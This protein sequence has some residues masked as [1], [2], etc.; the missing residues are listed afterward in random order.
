MTRRI[1][2]RANELL[3]SRLEGVARIPYAR[4]RRAATTH[5]FDYLRTYVEDLASVVDMEKI[6]AASLSIGVDP[7]GGASAAYWQPIAERYGLRLEVVNS[8]V[9]PRFGFMPLDWD[10]RIRMDC[11]SPHA[12]A[13]L[14]GLK[15]RFD[16]AFG[17]DPDADRHGIVTRSGGLMNPNH[18]LAAA[19]DY[20]FTHR[21]QWPA[22]AAVG[23][24]VVSSIFI[25]RVAAALGRRLVEVPVGFKWFVSGLLDGSLGFGGEESAGASFL[26]RDGT[27]W[28]TDKDG[29]IMNLLAAEI[30]GA[31]GVIR[32][33]LTPTSP[34]SWALRC[35]SAS[36]RRPRRNRRRRCSACRPPTSMPPSWPAIPSKRWSRRRPATAP[37]SAV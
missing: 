7:L 28:A 20:L 26:R 34:T 12:M 11:S 16:V 14:I 31:T 30:L 4:A 27:T 21:P 19:I 3:S 6:R 10:G 23:K 2:E 5:S 36:T 24:T 35:T 9:D 1:E 25:D 13:R 37:R 18:Y 15:D 17:N 32:P 8:Q 29:I 22:A 33:G